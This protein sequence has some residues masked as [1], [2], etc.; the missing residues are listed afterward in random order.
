MRVANQLLACLSIIAWAR[1][2]VNANEAYVE[3]AGLVV[4]EAENT[5]SPLGQWQ[6]KDA[7]SGYTG[8]G[9]LDFAG[10][11][12]LTGPANSPLRYRFKISKP[13]LYYLHLL[14]ARETRVIKGETRKDVANDCYVRIEG[15]FGAGPNPGNQHG[16]NAPLSLLK[17]DTK[18]FGGKDQAF[19]WVAGNH[20][21]PGGHNNKRVAVY[22]FKTQGVY[23]MVVSGRSK[24]FKLD[25]IV[26]RH[27][28]VPA[29]TAQ[30]R[31][32]PETL[33]GAQ[34]TTSSEATSGPGTNR[35][36]LVQ[37]PA[38]RL[39]IVADGNSPDPD[40][41][42]ATAVMF[43]LLKSSGLSKR[44]VHLSHSCDLKPVA[45]ISAADERR[46]QQSSRRFQL[47]HTTRSS[48]ERFARCNQTAIGAWDW[49][50]K[51]RDPDVKWIW[52]QLKYA[53]R[54]GVV[55]FQTNK[56]DCS[57][58]GM[59]YWWITGADQGGNAFAT[60]IEIKTMLDK[61]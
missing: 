7:I 26:F 4:I 50:K 44:L 21:D 40:D 32:V 37:P 47:P 12:Y 20:L 52:K 45:R 5:P 33:A 17:K 57:D 23:T 55:K 14:C 48:G 29:K 25:R 19:V 1:P 38:G 16:D 15:D 39:A 34:A 59:V 28:S 36:N 58:A 13:G 9:Y 43:G 56:F 41:I 2:S 51:S 60:P 22:R 54:D 42:G 31:E 11:D 30:D 6:R 49:A 10:N 3:R 46:R 18:F 27:Q 53:E 8:S 35:T 24:G 61:S